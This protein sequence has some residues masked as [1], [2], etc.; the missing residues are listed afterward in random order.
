MKAFYR[1][2]VAGAVATSLSGCATLEKSDNRVLCALLGGAIGGTIGAVAASDKSDEEAGVAA[3]V[4]GAGLGYL[5]CHRTEETITLPEA[6]P[7]PA[8]APAPVREQPR[9]S[10][11]DGVLDTTDAC[12][13]T[14]R[15]TRVDNRGCPVAGQTLLRLE[16]VT[17]AYDS[18]TLTADAKTTLDK[19]VPMLKD[20]ASVRVNVD[21]HTDSR[22]SEQYNQ[23]LSQRRA[24]AVVDYLI[25]KGI[26]RDQLTARG[27]GESA[28][29]AANDSEANMARNRRVEFVVAQ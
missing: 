25:E 12:P 24:Q 7:T 10:D 6:A 3:G 20:N 15:G 19:A 4:F 14:P 9:D 1:L 26:A 29:V 16:G 27:F 21:G 22:G 28:P 13:N 5:L 2:A 23:S 8:P 18:A 11:G 17:F